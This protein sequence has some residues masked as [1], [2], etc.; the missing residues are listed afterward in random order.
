MDFAG[1]ARGEEDDQELHRMPKDEEETMLSTDGPSS[2]IESFYN[3]S[4]CSLRHQSD[5]SFH[6]VDEDKSEA[7]SLDCHIH[8]LPDE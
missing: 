8:L 4:I 6:G 2:E 7:K 3:G 1:N 5:G